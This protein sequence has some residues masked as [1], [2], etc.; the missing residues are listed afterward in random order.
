MD[1]KVIVA[2]D[3]LTRDRALSLAKNLSGHVWGFKVNDLLLDC[4][5]E[6]I[7]TL[8]AFGSVFA[9]P[10]LHDIPNTVAN[11][12]TKISRAGADLITIHA[13]AGLDALVA[14]NAVKGDSKLLAITVLTS[15]GSETV[16]AVYG[17]NIEAAVL[18]FAASAKKAAFDG[19]VCSPKE[20]ELLSADTD[21]KDLLK[22]T[23]GV[24]PAWFDRR[25]DDQTRVM[26]PEDALNLGADYLVIGRPILAADDPVEAANKIAED[27][28]RIRTKP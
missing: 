12:V 16:S 18:S 4:G 2:L 17:K 14:A 25:S 26:T 24:R 21:A 6:I 13:S 1:S 23:P 8:K 28:G 7:S 22:V 5:V 19:V 11:S 27:I 9:D 20:L 10:K 15:L 3:G